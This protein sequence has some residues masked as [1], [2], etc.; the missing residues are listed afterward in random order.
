MFDHDEVVLHYAEFYRDELGYHDIEADIPNAG[1]GQPDAIDY[2]PPDGSRR[3]D[4]ISIIDLIIIEVESEEDIGSGD[5]RSQW[6]VFSQWARQRN[7]QFLI[8]VPEGAKP[9]AEDV[10]T[11][12]GIEN[13]EVEEY[14]E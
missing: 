9:D 7:A 13:A 14:T 6:N 1:F 8:V 4:V 3:P 2:G 11:E 10:L 12:L 5:S